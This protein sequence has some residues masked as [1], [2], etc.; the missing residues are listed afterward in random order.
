M[1]AAAQAKWG[2]QAADE[3]EYANYMK[4]VGK[5]S[6]IGYGLQLRDLV[7]SSSSKQEL[8]LVFQLK[9][10]ILLCGCNTATR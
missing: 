4:A 8:S 5:S 7:C 10:T 6:S 3:L 2:S 1:R 9:Q